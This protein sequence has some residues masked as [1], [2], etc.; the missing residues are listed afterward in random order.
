LKKIVSFGE[1]MLRLTPFH[2][3]RIEQAKTLSIEYGGSES[4][5][6]ASL[7]QLGTAVNYVSRVPDN[8]F[9]LSALACMEGWGV[10]TQHCIYGGDRLGIYFV[11]TGAGRRNS[12]VIYDRTGSSMYHLSPGMINWATIFKDA[13]WFHWSGI[14]PSIS[15]SAA[16]ACKEA[17]LAAREAGLMISCDLNYR[18]KLWKYGVHPDKIMPELIQDC[19]VISGDEDVLDTYFKIKSNNRKDAFEKLQNRFPNAKFISFTER[20]GLSATHNTYQGYLFHDNHIYESKKHD[21]PDIIDRLGTG[22]AF[23]AGLIHKLHGANQ[24]K[25]EIQLCIDFATAVAVHKHYVAGDINIV[26]KEEVESL[27]AGNTGA[28]V[29]R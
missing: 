20:E 21:I 4:N 26:S 27:M 10:N 5:V 7:A 3:Q 23:I 22:D 1:I 11:E 19:D 17:V 2:Y 12:K 28:K 13:Q 8:S 6:A 14:T 9:G 29:R 15:Q 16:N 24:Y 25:E 18:S